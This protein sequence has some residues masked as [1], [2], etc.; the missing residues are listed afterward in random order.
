MK[1]GELALE[2]GISVRTLHYYDETS[3]L[4]PS[5]RSES[6]H[7]IYGKSDIARLHRI[8]CLKKLNLSLEEIRDVIGRP[9]AEIEALLDRNIESIEVDIDEKK[10]TLRTLRGTRNF[11]GL[12][13]GVDLAE[14][15]DFIKD[16][17]LAQKYFSEN[18]LNDMEKREERIGAKEI[19]QIYSDIPRMTAEIRDAF[20]SKLPPSTPKVVEAVRRWSEI[21]DTLVGTEDEG[22]V[23]VA[24]K[25]VKENPEVLSRH[26]L[27]EEM[28]DY[29]RK[30]KEYL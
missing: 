29:M 14:L 22:T 6:G 12:K 1:I 10:E 3:L 23:A 16:I 7:R 26:E 19:R 17:S 13:D 18:Q 15:I 24:K 30:A 25:I 28:V 4:S 2:T 8:L 9:N 27:S 20:E 11:L 21:A 5:S